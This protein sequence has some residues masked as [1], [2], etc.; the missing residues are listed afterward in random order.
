MPEE[1]EHIP[2]NTQFD[3]LLKDAFLELDLDDPKNEKL[4]ESVS[5]NV[6]LTNNYPGSTNV[7]KKLLSGIRLQSVLILSVCAI[8]VAAFLMYLYNDSPVTNKPISPVKSE[9]KK[10]M[11][12]ATPQPKENIHENSIDPSVKDQPLVINKNKQELTLV[13]DTSKIS[14]PADIDLPDYTE[15]IIYSSTSITTQRKHDS[16]YVFPKLTEKEVKANNKQ[17]KKMAEQLLKFNKNQY[18]LI[19]AGSFVYKGNTKISGDFYM[20]THEVTNLEYRTF[21]FDLLIRDEKEAFLKAK[22][23]QSLWVN[24]TGDHK[25]DN[26]KEMYFSDKSFNDH[27]VV[28]IPVE[29]AEM[30]CTWLSEIGNELAKAK[31]DRPKEL[32]VRLPKEEEWVYSAKGGCKRGTYPWGSDSIQNR[33]NRFLANF[34]V[35]KEKEKF[36]QPIIYQNKTNPAAY[37]SAGYVLNKDT[38]ATVLAFAYNPNDYGLYCM[39]GNASEWVMSSDLKSTTALGGNWSSDLEHLK[40]NSESEFKG[41]IPASPFIGFRPV[42]FLKK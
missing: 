31:S 38:V 17:K 2:D 35:Q 28:N 26:Y 20:E 5:K 22:P 33:Y 37:T 4:V 6:L 32:S 34:C 23:N 11:P 40:I 25:Y 7:L 27:P 15:P 30:Y 36:N 12:H 1:F 19:P 24:C 41:K 13:T 10:E 16:I 9:V 42:V 14:P 18:C 39:S 29:G 21:L 3:A 8:T